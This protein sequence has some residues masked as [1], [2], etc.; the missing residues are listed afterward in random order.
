[1]PADD[2][3][4]TILNNPFIAVDWNPVLLEEQYNP[5]ANELL[6]HATVASLM[7]E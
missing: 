5:T 6:E 3:L 1:M 2:T 4:L 7:A